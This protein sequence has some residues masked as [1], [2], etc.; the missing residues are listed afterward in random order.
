VSR[1]EAIVPQSGDSGVLYVG[2]NGLEKSQRG[3]AI[4]FIKGSS[5]DPFHPFDW[6]VEVYRRGI[7]GGTANRGN[8][9]IEGD[10]DQWVYPA[11]QAFLP[12]STEGRDGRTA[13]SGD[14]GYLHR[15]WTISQRETHSR[16]PLSSGESKRK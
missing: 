15:A 6:E 8:I 2:N 7:S 1:K 5:A 13:G 3:V 11:M 16:E 9:A 10:E 12:P 14:D 4:R